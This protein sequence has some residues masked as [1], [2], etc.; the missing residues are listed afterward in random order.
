M[1]P[2]MWQRLM[3]ATV[4]MGAA[5]VCWGAAGA[6]WALAKIMNPLHGEDL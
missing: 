1:D 5:V 2:E 4:L 6:S 3:I